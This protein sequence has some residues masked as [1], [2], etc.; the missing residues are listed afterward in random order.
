MM[1]R[2]LLVLDLDETLIYASPSVLDRPA[3]FTAAYH[4]V[5]RR[6]FLTEFLAGVAALYELTV[7]TSAAPDYAQAVCAAIFDGASSPAFIWDRRRC[8]IRRNADTDS[9]VETKPLKK[10]ARR[11]YDLNRIVALDDSPEKYEQNHGNLVRVAPF[12]GAATDD[13]L[14]HALA[15]LTQLA[16]VANVRTV[17]KRGWQQKFRRATED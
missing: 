9:F 5:Y 1:A 12:E 15:Y 2:H 4:H 16:T 13:E 7:W 6:P 11:G 17:E 3:D 14:Q 8:T 10:L